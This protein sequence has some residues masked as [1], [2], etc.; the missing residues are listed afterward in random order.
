MCFDVFVFRIWM[1][2]I[3]QLWVR[4]S[5]KFQGRV[6]DNQEQKT[7]GTRKS[8]FVKCR[9]SNLQNKIEWEITFDLHNI[10][11]GTK[12]MSND[13]SP[14]TA[15]IIDELFKIESHEKKIRHSKRRDLQATLRDS[16]EVSYENTPF[17]AWCPEVNSPIQ[18]SILTAQDSHQSLPHR[19]RRAAWRAWS[20][21]VRMGRR[22]SIHSILRSFWK[23][24]RL[25]SSSPP[26]R[27]CNKRLCVRRNLR[28]RGICFVYVSPLMRI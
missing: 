24:W 6:T 21:R 4:L 17:E 28:R 26:N 12:E 13:A 18:E 25:D 19:G 2:R 9:T 11:I 14:H 10:Q 22:N 8:M 16:E 3:L 1:F 15:E 20:S 7:D 27:R 23:I 5:A